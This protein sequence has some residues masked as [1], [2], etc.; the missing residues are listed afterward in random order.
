VA[1][2]GTEVIR[3][4]QYC[5]STHQPESLHVDGLKAQ[6]ATCSQFR[7]CLTTSVHGK[8]AEYKNINFYEVLHKLSAITK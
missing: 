7:Y 3:Q 2:S 1:T 6:A 4:M 5:R 8:L